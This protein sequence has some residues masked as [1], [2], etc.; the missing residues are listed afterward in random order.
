MNWWY[1]LRRFFFLQSFKEIPQQEH[2]LLNWNSINQVCILLPNTTAH[3][4]AEIQ[5]AVSSLEKENISVSCLIFNENEKNNNPLPSF[6]S[7]DVNWHFVPKSTAID[8]FTGQKADMLFAFYKH[9][10]LTLDFIVQ[11]SKATCRIGYFDEAK[12]NQFEF[13]IKPT[14]GSNQT[15]LKL[16]THSIQYLQKIENK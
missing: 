4:A 10:N 5:E 2:R 14:A 13:M 16:L 11:Q 15:L 9:E 3:T 1:R 7:K 8:K 12:T 6:T